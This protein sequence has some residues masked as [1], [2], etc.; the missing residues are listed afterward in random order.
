MAKKTGRK[1]DSAVYTA[2][3]PQTAATP[4]M[5]ERARALAD[6]KYQGSIGKLIRVALQEKFDREGGKAE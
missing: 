1:P 6:D 4:D 5:V 2:Y 3:L